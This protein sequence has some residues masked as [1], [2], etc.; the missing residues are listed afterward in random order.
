MRFLSLVRSELQRLGAEDAE[1]IAAEQELAR[2]QAQA[3]ALLL[4]QDDVDRVRWVLDRAWYERRG[5]VL[6]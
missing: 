1:M 5:V 3:R 4:A 6:D 2:V